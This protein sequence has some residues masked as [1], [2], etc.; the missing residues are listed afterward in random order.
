[1]IAHFAPE[2]DLASMS[3]E[4]ISTLVAELEV[5]LDKQHAHLEREE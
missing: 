5:E 3:E 1:M 2:I 4:A